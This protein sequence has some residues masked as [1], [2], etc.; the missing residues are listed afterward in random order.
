MGRCHYEERCS[1]VLVLGHLRML[2]FV[3]AMFRVKD[4]KLEYVEKVSRV[5][6]E[7]KLFNK[8][9][10]QGCLNLKE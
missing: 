2:C 1:G 4:A 8:N 7:A 9:R 3:G 6:K 5:R 10:S